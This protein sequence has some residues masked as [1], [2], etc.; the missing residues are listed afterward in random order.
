[1]G[2]LIDIYNKRCF[3]ETGSPFRNTSN[4]KFDP[5]RHTGPGP[6]PSAALSKCQCMLEQHCSFFLAEEANFMV[7]PWQQSPETSQHNF[8]V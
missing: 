2:V 3:S 8:V 5:L 1:M 4:K 7:I 6:N